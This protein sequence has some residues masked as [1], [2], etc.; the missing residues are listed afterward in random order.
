M[1]GKGSPW[2]HLNTMQDLNWYVIR[3]RSNFERPVTEALQFKGFTTFLPLYRVRQRWSDRVKEMDLP[4]FSGYTFCKFDPQHRLP[5]LMTPGVVSIVGSGEKPLPVE[6]SEIA[7]V[8]AMLQSGL[9]L[10][11]WPF[12]S[13]GQSVLVKHGPL[14]GVEGL[15]VSI[16]NK[17][18][19]IVSIS[20]LQRSVSV[21][22]DRDC[23]APAARSA[24]RAA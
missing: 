23:V 15:I 2:G 24:R 22:I 4:L 12:L 19:L 9:A 1:F 6:E 3:T 11:P 7:A 13:E 16:K 8:R 17:Y 10:G 14:E 20:I 5:M 18:R 21:E